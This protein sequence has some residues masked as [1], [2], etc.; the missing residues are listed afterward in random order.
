[1]DALAD[2]KEVSEVISKG[3]TKMTVRL[4][5]GIN[6]DLRVVGIGCFG[7]ALQ[8]FTGSRA[9]NVK[10]RKIAVRKGYKLNE[11]GLFDKKKISIAGREEKEIYNSLGMD[12]IDPEMREDRGEIELAM[13]HGLP[14][15][16]EE[17]D[18][19][20]DLHVHTEY[21]DG[22]ESMENMLLE[23]ARMGREYI[24]FT[25]HSKSEH[26]A[27]GMDRKKFEKYA[28]EIERLNGIYEEKITVLKSSETDILKNGDLDWD[29]KSLD[30]MDYVLASVHTGLGMSEKEMTQRV[31]K[32]MESGNIDILGHPT[33]RL[34]N[35]R[36]PL[37]IDMEK[38]FEAAE[39]NGVA[40]EINALPERLDLNDRNILLAKNYRVKF[41]INTD[42]HSISHLHSMKYGI[43]MARK[44]WV[45]SSEVINTKPLKDLKKFFG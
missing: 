24:G 26:V 11:Y 9:H 18:I 16:I 39:K 6:C 45:E 38:I 32:C 37:N 43:G 35:Q 4:D 3:K 7:S 5:S 33:D 27:K 15:L 22:T 28:K 21:S 44:G 17:K 34:I 14:V 13:K 2:S 8:Y 25:D 1:M 36:L 19:V 23:A 10:L 12:Y 29:R 31:V 30:E 40:L 42:S 20:G 41:A